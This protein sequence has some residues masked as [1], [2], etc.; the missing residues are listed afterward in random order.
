V[1]GD[2]NAARWV[3]GDRS[4]F[5]SRGVGLTTSDHNR[6][7]TMARNRLSD[8]ALS[9]LLEIEREAA[10]TA[11]QQEW[12]AY[13]E[14]LDR[15]AESAAGRAECD[16]ADWRLAGE[17]LAGATHDGAGFLLVDDETIPW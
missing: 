12:V 16:F 17:Y 10:D 7:A 8:D 3:T 2:E 13:S 11:Y 6:S 9:V 1:V 14:W 5:D 4:G 15:H